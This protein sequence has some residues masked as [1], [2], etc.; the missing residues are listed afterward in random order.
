MK[1]LSQARDLQNG[2]VLYQCFIFGYSKLCVQT[3]NQVQWPL[4]AC[5]IM[6]CKLFYSNT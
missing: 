4:V 1:I 5:F 2:I 6:D 3:W